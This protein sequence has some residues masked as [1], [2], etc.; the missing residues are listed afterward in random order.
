MDVE[1]FWYSNDVSLEVCDE[2]VEQMQLTKK[3][4]KYILRCKGG[5]SLSPSGLNGVIY[6]FNR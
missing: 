1:Q 4:L 3:L 6:Y 2:I 5:L